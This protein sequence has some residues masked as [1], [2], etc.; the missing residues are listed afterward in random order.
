MNPD[1]VKTLS[2]SDNID[3][4]LNSWIAPIRLSGILDSGYPV[5]CSLW[6]EYA[7][8]ALW[9]ATQKTSKIARV[10]ANN[11][12]CAFE[13]SP[14]EPPYFGV[15]GQG[16]AILQADKADELLDRLI[17]RY[18]GNSDSRLAKTLLNKVANEVAIKIEPINIYT[19]D[20]RKRMKD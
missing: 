20:Y 16:Q 10:F 5:I 19:W 8:N 13:L 3:S 2:N 6:F 15:R 18:L 7:D 4:F 14:N 17:I 1:T 12:R 9:C 11:P